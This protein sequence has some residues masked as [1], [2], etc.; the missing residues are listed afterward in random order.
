M[1][2]RIE[3]SCEKY[4]TPRVISVLLTS[5]CLKNCKKMQLFNQIYIVRFL[6]SIIPGGVLKKGYLRGRLFK[7]SFVGVTKVE[8]RIFRVG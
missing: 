5:T 2:R 6:S 8:C 4:S 3:T 7:R 1:R